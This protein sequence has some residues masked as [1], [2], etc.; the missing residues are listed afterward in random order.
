MGGKILGYNTRDVIEKGRCANW[1]QLTD[2]SHKTDK[3]GLGFI[4]EAQR[5]VRHTR[6]GKPPLH[7]NNPGVNAIEDDEEESDIDGWI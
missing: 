2:F 5:A 3:F 1:G 6:I 4:A 7:I